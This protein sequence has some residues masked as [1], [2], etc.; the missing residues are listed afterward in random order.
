MDHVLGPYKSSLSLLLNKDG[1][2]I[3]DLVVTRQGEN[4]QVLISA[5]I[6]SIS[7]I[8]AVYA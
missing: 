8:G 7:L 5:R 1:G 6:N 3:D 4:E 2:I